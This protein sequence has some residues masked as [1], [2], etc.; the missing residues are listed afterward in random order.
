MHAVERV[1]TESSRRP[2]LVDELN[3]D[4]GKKGPRAIG[5]EAVKEFKV[6]CELCI[7]AVV[8]VCE[9]FGDVHVDPGGL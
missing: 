1:R 7:I 4:G 2:F 5:T 8:D 3:D 6:D 9:S